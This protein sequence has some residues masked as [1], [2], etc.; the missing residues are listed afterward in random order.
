VSDSRLELTDPPPAKCI[1]CGRTSRI[2]GLLG[3]D[4]CSPSCAWRD[5]GASEERERIVAWLR[6]GAGS[7]LMVER[8]ACNQTRRIELS[9]QGWALNEKA[10][11]IERG[12]HRE[13]T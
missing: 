12:E 3:S 7:L 1:T 13:D 8:R 5:V 6:A 10:T 9:A 4:V 2:A 11:A